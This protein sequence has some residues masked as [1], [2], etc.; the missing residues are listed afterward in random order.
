M[1][2]GLS[3]LLLFQCFGELARAYTDVIL[4]G[5]VIGMLLL[6]LALCCRQRVPATLQ[7]S[8][9]S[10]IALMTLMFIPA[11]T[12]LFFLN[13]RFM[14]QWLAIALALIVGT[15]ISLIFNA[16]LMQRMVKRRG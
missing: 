7:Q 1:I 2:K 8:S 3:I 5:P 9:Q 14:S 10:L 12:G 11:T 15:V 6:F 16:W 4:P 13:D